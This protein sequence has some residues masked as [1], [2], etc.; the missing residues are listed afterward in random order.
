MKVVLFGRNLNLIR[1]LIIKTGFKI[2]KRD[3]EFVISYGGEGTLMQSE[4]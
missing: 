3:P 2:V 1:P 4:Y